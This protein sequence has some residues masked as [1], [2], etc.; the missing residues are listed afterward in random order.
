MTPKTSLLKT[1]LKTKRVGQ[2]VNIYLHNNKFLLVNT[3]RI[4]CGNKTALIL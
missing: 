1:E 3:Q 2:I 4:G